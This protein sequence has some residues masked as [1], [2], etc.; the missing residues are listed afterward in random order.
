[1]IEDLKQILAN[2]ADGH[3]TLHECGVLIKAIEELD[4]ANNFKKE[5]AERFGFLALKSE[6]GSFASIDEVACLFHDRY[7][8]TSEAV[9]SSSKLWDARRKIADAAFAEFDMGA[10]EVVDT[11]GWHTTTPGVEWTRKFYIVDTDDEDQDSKMETFVVIFDAEDS[12][13]ISS[14]YVSGWS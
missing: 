13:V 10:L 3:L 6:R 7:A 12:E 11:E 1:M 14:A 2:N 9:A 8:T 5:W 4:A